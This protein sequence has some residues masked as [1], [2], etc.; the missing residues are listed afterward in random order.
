MGILTVS[1]YLAQPHTFHKIGFLLIGKCI[2]SL[3][4][5]EIQMCNS[6]LKRFKHV[7]AKAIAHSER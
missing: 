4:L 6:E 5:P 7:K 1:Q 2:L 3:C